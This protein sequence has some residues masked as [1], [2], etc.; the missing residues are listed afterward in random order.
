MQSS[1]IKIGV[2]ND[3]FC[4]VVDDREYNFTH[5]FDESDY[6]SLRAAIRHITSDTV[7]IEME[8]WY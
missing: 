7:D 5:Y 8:E 2:M 6:E 4:V 3:G 1:K